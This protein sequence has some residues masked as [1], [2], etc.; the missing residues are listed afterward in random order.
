[1]ERCQECGRNEASVH[2][3]Q[4]VENQTTLRHLC[5]SCARKNGIAIEPV[6]PPQAPTEEGR[7]EEKSACPHCNLSH[8][9]FK[10]EGRLGCTH[11]YRTFAVSIEELLLQVHGAAKHTGKR[12]KNALALPQD[13]KQLKTV[14]ARAVKNEEFELAAAIRDAIHDLNG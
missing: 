12:Y 10:D 14:L 9:E 6:V 2:I 7:A 1:M 8:K 4:I 13:L 5:E 3:T 11:C